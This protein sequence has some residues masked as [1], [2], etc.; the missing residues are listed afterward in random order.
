MP[1]AEQSEATVYSRSLAGIMGSI[2][3]GGSEVCEG[4]CD[5]PIPHP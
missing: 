5:A 2:P 4:L 1:V 3:M